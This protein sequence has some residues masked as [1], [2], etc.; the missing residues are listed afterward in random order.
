MLRRAGL[1]HLL[2][3]A[4]AITRH[5]RFLLIGSA[6]A[7]ATQPRLPL[8]MMLTS[9]A[10]LCPDG[11]AAPEELAELL[12]ASIGQA[13]PFHRTFGY[14]ADGVGPA[15]AILPEGWRDRLVSY[16]SPEAPGVTALCLDMADLAVAKLCAGR[17]KDI[18][19]LRAALQAGLLGREVVE[20]RLSLLADPRAPGSA[21]LEARLA[22]AAG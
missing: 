7:I 11:V 12:S 13:S 15:T 19:W 3:A 1:D 9:E 5:D 21:V 22:A 16:A 2:R 4:A 14:Y 17:Q 20:A 18:D 10:D 6:A 8:S